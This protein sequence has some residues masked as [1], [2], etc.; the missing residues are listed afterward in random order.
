MR[1]EYRNSF[2]SLDDK[3]GI[4]DNM[5]ALSLSAYAISP[6]NTGNTITSPSAELLHFSHPKFLHAKYKA[7]NGFDVISSNLVGQ[8]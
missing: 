7:T 1:S 8:L 2:F 3:L 4:H 6:G 5:R